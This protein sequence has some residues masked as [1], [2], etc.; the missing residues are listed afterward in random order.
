MDEASRNLCATQDNGE[1]LACGKW[2]CHESCWKQASLKA[3]ETNAPVD[4]ECSG[5]IRLYALPVLANNEIIGALNFGYGNPPTTI[6]KLSELA[7]KYDIPVDELEKRAAMYETRPPYIIGSA[8]ERLQASAN[9]IGEIVTRKIS[10][11]KIIELNESLEKTVAGKT[12]ELKER[13]KELERF[14][15]ATIDREF[16]IKELRD[17]IELLRKAKR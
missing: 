11:Q 16:R 14:H 6:Q 3:I 10:E 4:I 17:E 8:K 9:L 7:E 5:G 12:M 1:A 13:I 2:H 15:E